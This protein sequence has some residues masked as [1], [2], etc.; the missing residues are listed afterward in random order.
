[1]ITNGYDLWLSFT[2]VQTEFSSTY[3]KSIKKVICSKGSDI[4]KVAA[5]ELDRALSLLFSEEVPVISRDSLEYQ[6]K[7]LF[8]G[9][10]DSFSPELASA[11]NR[12]LSGDGY[13]IFSYKSSFVIA[14]KTDKGVLYGI[15][16]FLRLLQTGKSLTCLDICSNP[17]FQKRMLDHWDNLDGSIERGYAGKSLWNWSE[18]PDHV[19]RRY[20]DYAR[21]CASV[22]LNC[23]VLNNVN[24]QP[25]IL[26]DEYIE[27]TAAIARV[28]RRY[29]ITVYLSVNFASPVSLGGLKT[30][31][32]LDED[33]V[34]WWQEKCASIYARIPDF[35]GFLVKADCEGQAGPFEYGRNHADGANMLAKALE[36]YGGMVIWRAFVYGHGE[37]DRAKKAYADFK[38]LDGNFLSNVA[39]QVKN[40]PIDFQP[41]EPVHPLFGGMKK[42]TMFMEMQAA[43]EYLGQGNHLVFLAPMW[44]EILDFDTRTCGTGSTV[45][46]ILTRSK[47]YGFFGTTSGIA[48]VSNTGSNTDWCGSLF[49]P[50]NWYAFGRLAWDCSLSPEEIAEEWARCTWGCNETVLQSVMF[51]LLNSWNACLDYM[52]PLCLHHIMRYDHHYGPDPGCTQGL[53]E[54]WKPPYYHRADKKGLGFDRT[55]SGSDAVSQYSPEVAEMFG[56]LETCPEKYLLW[57]HHV[58]WNYRLSSGR[59][60]KEELPFV[61]GRGVQEAVALRNEWLKVKGLVSDEAFDA[62]LKKL[63]IQVADAEEWRDV[64]VP[65]FLSFAE[66]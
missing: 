36:P 51:I 35:G 33:V 52:T 27:K 20:T 60:L 42:T 34:K 56:N 23:S 61:Y 9:T 1:M 32:P 66:D 45:G 29:G 55:S 65:Y 30:A 40:G 28:F 4:L 41:R 58:P 12:N 21:A 16:A 25:Y 59:T 15:F 44:K 3:P 5:D 48:A 39:I 31:D 17:A 38:P 37:T 62:V 43:Q 57:F 47:E 24:S 19:D 6:E 22:G 26:S 14:G 10:E 11:V 49:H 46:K 18:L 7:T 13:H 64:C 63:D 53:R 8:A 54:D 2:P 50:A